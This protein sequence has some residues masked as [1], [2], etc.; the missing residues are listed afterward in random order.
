MESAAHESPPGLGGEEG[1]VP[2][3]WLNV[4]LHNKIKWNQIV[5]FELYNQRNA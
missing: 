4:H 2:F 1:S 3:R 5:I